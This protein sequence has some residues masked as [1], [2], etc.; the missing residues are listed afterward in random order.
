[1][2]QAALLPKFPLFWDRQ[3]ALPG[4]I[5]EDTTVGTLIC[6]CTL[7]ITTSPAQ[8]GETLLHV[9]EKHTNSA[10][11]WFWGAHSPF[12]QQEPDVQQMSP[13]PTAPPESQP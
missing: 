3:D 4:L 10:D 2:P 11:T 13:I 1:M 5:W 6:F 12:Q 8:E 7:T 9:A